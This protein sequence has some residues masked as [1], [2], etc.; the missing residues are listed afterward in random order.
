MAVKDARTYKVLR[1]Y[2]RIGLFLEPGDTVDLPPEVAAW[3]ERDSVGTLEAERWTIP[4][5]ANAETHVMEAPPEDRMVRQAV[6]RE[7][8]ALDEPATPHEVVF[9]ATKSGRKR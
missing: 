9:G 7:E 8:A 6:V 5:D 3:I 4:A 2:G 1:Y